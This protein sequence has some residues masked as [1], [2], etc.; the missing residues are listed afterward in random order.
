QYHDKIFNLFQ[1]LDTE[2]EGSGIG[3]TIVKR[4]AEL[5][6]GRAWVESKPGEGAAFI[7]SLPS[8]RPSAKYTY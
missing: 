1:R 3:L 8:L 5:H 4:V 7:V 6:G 2:S